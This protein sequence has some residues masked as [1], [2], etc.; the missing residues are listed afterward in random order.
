[1]RRLRDE[2]NERVA[3]GERL[4]EAIDAVRRSYSILPASV[5]GLLLG[6]WPGIIV[7][8]LC[9]AAATSPLIIG[10]QLYLVMSVPSRFIA[11]GYIVLG[12]TGLDKRV[13]TG[14]GVLAYSIG[15]SLAYLA[16]YG[17]LAG[18]LELYTVPLMENVFF[19]ATL[20]ALDTAYLF[21]TRRHI[22]EKLEH[23]EESGHGEHRPG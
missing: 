17:Y 13:K 11:P 16:L 6:T 18:L 12:L 4:A 1:M 23:M 15:L 19:L 8:Y 22:M 21:K 10:T 3:R 14:A 7:I 2:I 20:M 5:P 9:I